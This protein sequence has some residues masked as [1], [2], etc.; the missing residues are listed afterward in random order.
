[1]GNDHLILSHDCFAA[2]TF[3]KIICGPQGKKIKTMFKISLIVIEGNSSSHQ[4]CSL[5]SLKYVWDVLSILYAHILPLIAGLDVMQQIPPPPPPHTHTIPFQQSP[6]PGLPI[7]VE[8]E[9]T[10]NG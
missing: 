9:E 1:M 5:M 3:T 7:R 2:N 6:I 4:R 8:S 10:A